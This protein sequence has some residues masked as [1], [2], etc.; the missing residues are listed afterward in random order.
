MAT[1]LGQCARCRLH[2][3]SNACQV[4]RRVYNPS[5]RSSRARQWQVI[6]HERL[7]STTRHFRTQPQSSSPVDSSFPDIEHAS[8]PVSPRSPETN[9]REARQTFGDV[10]PPGYLSPEEYKIY[11]R[12]YGQPIPVDNTLDLGISSPGIPSVELLRE[13]DD[14]TLTD[15]P[16]RIEENDDD[17]VAQ[18]L[19]PIESDREFKRLAKSKKAKFFARATKPQLDAAI[20]APAMSRSDEAL[21]PDLSHEWNSMH[22]VGQQMYL[23]D[24]RYLKLEKHLRQS[25]LPNDADELVQCLFIRYQATKK[26][27]PATAEQENHLAVSDQDH[28]IE[29]DIGADPRSH[30]FTEANRF[31]TFPSTLQL[32]K[33]TF[34]D[35]INAMFADVSFPALA[36]AA[37]RIFGGEHVPYSP[38]TPASHRGKEQKPLPLTAFQPEMGTTQSNAYMAAVY[39]GIYASVT[40]TLVETRKRL[41]Q[42]WLS[43]LMSKAGG[44]LVLDA[45]GA[46]AGI[47]AV[48]DVLRAEWESMHD[49]SGQEDAPSSVAV[50]GGETGGAPTEV[51]Y[52]K[53]TVVVGSDSL[54][55]RIS[56]LLDNT[57]FVPRLP[58]YVHASD[59]AAKQRG[60]FDIVIAPHTL[61]SIEEEYA[62]RQHLSKLWSL[63]NADGGVLIVL[64][65]GVP[66]AFDTI[67]GARQFLLD[68]RILSPEEHQL[69][70][71]TAVPEADEAPRKEP[72]M[73]VA[74]CTNH[75][76]CPMRKRQ[77]VK[78]SKRTI[79]HFEQ[80]YIRPPFLQRLV[81]ARDK[82]FEDIKFS[83]LS[84]MRGRDLRTEIPELVQ[85]DQAT[86]RAFAGYEHA[87]VET[88]E[89]SPSMDD[90]APF[91]PTAPALTD[92]EPSLT[93]SSIPHSLNLPRVV[94]PPLKRTGH[95]ILDLC[96]PSGRLERWTVPK[97]FSRQAYRDARKSSWGDLWALGAKTRVNK[98]NTAIADKL[99]TG[100]GRKLLSAG[101]S[102]K[103][104][105]DKDNRMRQREGKKSRRKNDERL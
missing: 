31:S 55:H 10:L 25:E 74:P 100:P 75:S 93:S 33:S 65:K 70:D 96:T 14:G 19:A 61:W 26:T 46:G 94:M 23:N 21:L 28:D 59:L 53:A 81:G 73:I 17:D 57:T 30:P 35:P 3:F 5:H 69:Q 52:G 87:A 9:A 13:A 12:L 38:S 36:S 66:N 11:E 41:G 54:R 58:D 67:A 34:T 91:D 77:G 72:G 39:P 29:D 1:L 49:T 37:H 90:T 7:L 48:R 62:R 104:G 32:P 16:Y 18:N 6:S 78:Q 76:A 22:S 60:K 82:N 97:S 40:S 98:D 43:G 63:V 24:M 51:P 99:P 84:V 8:V 2:A 92:I 50:A 88:G 47:L 45:G 68:K 101:D 15:V 42:D 89:L 85:G 56:P 105:K 64:E 95:V 86:S 71:H 44:P 103:K 80:R 102:V 83:Y 4:T 27:T 79:C 20:L